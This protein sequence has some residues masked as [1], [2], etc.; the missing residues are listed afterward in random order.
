MM[1]F[2]EQAAA[3]AAAGG[4]GGGGGGGGSDGYKICTGSVRA[5]DCGPVKIEGVFE[6]LDA[7]DEYYVD[8]ASSTLFL[9][10]NATRPSTHTAA[11]IPDPDA[12]GELIVT[13]ELRYATNSSDG[14]Q[15]G[16]CTAAACL[17]CGCGPCNSCACGK[18]CYT[19]C[20]A[21]HNC[22]CAACNGPNS[23]PPTPAPHFKPV[24]PPASRTLVVPHLQQLLVIQ[25]TYA[26]DPAAAP[27]T[28]P[29]SNITIR[30]I[31]FRDGAPTFL[32]PHGIPSGGDW[33][34]QRTAALFLQ[35]TEGVTVEHSR[36]KYLGG[37]AYQLSGYNRAA[38]VHDCEFAYLGGSAMTSW[39]Y[40]HSD[41][42]QVPAPR[43]TDNRPAQLTIAP[44]N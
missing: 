38:A 17:S 3:A 13:G 37:I 35:G 15:G 4:G 32:E 2:V 10:Y 30:G 19:Y 5:S 34:L 8:K 40:T 31:G 16:Q 1:L 43:S 28:A 26:G 27:P 29:V 39:G 24:P 7:P 25:G 42:P 9:F 6:E 44:L 36:F 20:Q 11:A 41:D 14:A 21:P 23:S 33:S 18:F 12:G 22:H